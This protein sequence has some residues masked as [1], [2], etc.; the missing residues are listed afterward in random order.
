VNWPSMAD[1]AAALASPTDFKTIPS[2]TCRSVCAPPRLAE[3]RQFHVTPLAPQ[4][5]HHGIDGGSPA[6]LNPRTFLRRFVAET[7]LQRM[8]ERPT[9][10][11]DMS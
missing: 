4:I 6:P 1:V 9:H 2:A 11:D 3:D 10:Q 8:E 5:P 7:H